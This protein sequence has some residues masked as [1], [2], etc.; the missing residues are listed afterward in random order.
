MKNRGGQQYYVWSLGVFLIFGV[1]SIAQ[2]ASALS[3]GGIGG[4]PSNPDPGIQYSDSWFIY[5]LDTGESKE[6]TLT[7]QNTSDQTQ[8]VKL[9]AVD[10]VATGDGNFALRDEKDP[11][12][13]VGAWIH[14]DENIVTLEP[15]TERGVRFAITIP[16]DAS[17]GEHSGGIILQKTNAPSVDV[18]SSG[19]SIVTRVGIRVYETVPGE[20][21]K[22]L[23]LATF[24]V[25]EETTAAKGTIYVANFGI[26]NKSNV[27]LKAAASVQVTGWGKTAWFPNSKFTNGLYL[28]FSD[29]TNFFKGAKLE[30]ELSLLRDKQVDMNLEWPKPVF[31]H[32]IFQA[33][34]SYDGVNGPEKLTSSAIDVWVIPWNVLG[35]IGILILLLLVW[36]IFGRMRGGGK[37]W[38]EYT[39]RPG[40]QLGTIASAA[41]IS[42]K[43]LAKANKL[44]TPTVTPG[45]TIR[46]PGKSTESPSPTV[47]R[48]QT[49]APM[50]AAAAVPARPRPETAQAEPLTTPATVTIKPRASGTAPVKRTRKKKI[51]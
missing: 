43:K 30:N 40:D 8:T 51:V 22:K 38:K 31:G 33:V 41:G 10:S 12:E 29:I 11:R 26:V 4:Y 44:K 24:T 16:V 13:G 47:P 34:V 3:S 37:K 42:W 25:R 15:G 39:V 50:P 5:N 32:F 1:I 6:D 2:Y 23:E 17:V 36:G 20:L 7:L 28:D 14:L 35:V 18:G 49:A 46:V 21:V 27:S 45:Q 19:A 48:V 9:Y